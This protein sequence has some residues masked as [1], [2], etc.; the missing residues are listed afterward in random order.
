MGAKILS[1]QTGKRIDAKKASRTT[2]SREY[3]CDNC[4]EP[5]MTKEDDRLRCPSCWLREQGQKIKPID[6]GGYRP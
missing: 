3:V 6:R 4:G 5:A 1:W 2:L